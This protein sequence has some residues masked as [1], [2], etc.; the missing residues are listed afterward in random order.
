MPEC[1]ACLSLADLYTPAPTLQNQSFPN[2][3]LAP[4]SVQG[5]PC[6]SNYAIFS[7]SQGHLSWA[8]ARAL[9]GRGAGGATLCARLTEQQ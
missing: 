6:M 1:V 2:C 7:C 5:L 8:P 9:M 4:S 3:L